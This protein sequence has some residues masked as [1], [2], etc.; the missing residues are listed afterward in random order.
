V[1]LEGTRLSLATVTPIAIVLVV[2]ADPIV[3]GWVGPAMIGAVP[4]IQVLAFATTLRVAN[5]TGT[6]LLKGSGQVKYLAGV[7]LGTGLANLVLSAVLVKPFGLVGVA[8]G[9]LIPITFSA[10]FIIFPAACRRVQLPVAQA[11]RH[12]IWPAAWP[13]AVVGVALFMVHRATQATLPLA[14]L[15]AAAAALLYVGL[16]IIAVGRRDR[17]IYTARIWELAT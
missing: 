7:N 9:T 16:F 11:L 1:L 15:E 12:A 4:V 5:A 10:V 3:R 13:G 6:T 14:V 8:I 2:L 17:A